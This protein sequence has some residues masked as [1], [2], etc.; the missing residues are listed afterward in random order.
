MSDLPPCRPWMHGDDRRVRLKVCCISSIEEAQTAIAHGADAIGLVSAMPSGPGVIDDARIEA[1]AAA[2]PPG[3]GTVLLTSRRDVDGIV[4]Q[5]R[6]FRVNTL[7]LCDEVEPTDIRTMR[8]ILDGVSIIQVVHVVGEES[9]RQAVAA[10]RAAH[11]LLLDSG[12]PSKSTRELGGTGRTHNWTLSRRICEA[13][14][15][16]VYLA[17]GLSPEN[18]ADAV[19]TVRPFGVDVCSGLRSDG[20]LDEHR[21]ASFVRRLKSSQV[22]ASG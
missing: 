14:V 19:R 2:V 12:D 1:I 13:V 21:L 18:I 17:G 16:P 8:S 15:G 6:R 22:G 3:I 4:A 9:I 20:L 11:A 10:S 5:Q 7:Q